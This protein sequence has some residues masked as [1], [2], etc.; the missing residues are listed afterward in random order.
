MADGF[1]LYFYNLCEFVYRSTFYN[2]LAVNSTWFYE[3]VGKENKSKRSWLLYSPA[4]NSLY[5]FCCLIFTD[6]SNKSSFIKKGGFNNWRKKEMLK[7]C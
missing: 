7:S 4:S 2:N 5:C 6:K 1:E 3:N